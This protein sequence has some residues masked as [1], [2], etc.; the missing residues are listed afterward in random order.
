MDEITAK[1]IELNPGDEHDEEVKGWATLVVGAIGS[2]GLEIVRR[3]CVICQKREN[4]VDEF[5]W[6]PVCRMKYPNKHPDA[7]P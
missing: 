2:L 6:C 1:V 4:G 3:A 5:N 7:G